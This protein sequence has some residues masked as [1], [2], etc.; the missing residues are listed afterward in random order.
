MA[1]QQ[2]ARARSPSSSSP[3][4]GALTG[5]YARLRQARCAAGLRWGVRWPWAER[6]KARTPRAM[7]SR[8]LPVAGQAER[9]ASAAWTNCRLLQLQTLNRLAYAR[10]KARLAWRKPWR[11]RC[12]TQ[13]LCTLP[14]GP[15]GCSARGPGRT[16]C[17]CLSVRARVCAWEWPRPHTISW[18]VSDHAAAA[19]APGGAVPGGQA[20]C[21]GAADARPAQPA[22]APAPPAAPG[23]RRGRGGAARHGARDA[24]AAGRA[25][26]GGAGHAVG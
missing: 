23:M 24:R 3:S 21:E 11:S 8:P 6:G 16:A 10:G 19:A 22:P 26:G 15:A 9:C 13:Q 17:A 2:A 5:W 25:G 12:I 20:G 14:E 1:V 4:R 18:W 7:H